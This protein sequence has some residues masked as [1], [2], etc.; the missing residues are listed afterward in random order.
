[1]LFHVAGKTL[2]LGAAF[3]GAV[4]LTA[5]AAV[6]APA[7]PPTF[8][9]DVAPIFQAKCE[10][11]HRPNSIAPMSLMS[12]EET[13]PWAR[14]IKTRIASRQMPP[15]HIDKTVG[16]QHFENDRSLSDE[17]IDTI[18]R[19]VD[20]GS[21]K[22]DPKDM[23]PPV[24]W[25]DDAG[26]NFKSRFGEPD[27]IVKSPAYRMPARA[28][29]AWY[30]P[31]VPTGLTEARW[32]RAIEIRPSTIK[33]RRIT[34]HALARL[35]QDDGTRGAAAS[36][37]APTGDDADV[38]PGLFMEWAVGK[39]GEVMRPNSGKLMLPG[40]KIV[41]DI[42]YHA[43]GE[44]ITDS[45]ELA[46]YFYP[47][48]QEPKFRQVLALFSGVTEG[49]RNLDIPPN[50][51]VVNQ[52]FHVMRQAGRVEN[53]QPHMHLRGKAM[54]MEAILPSGTTQMLSYVNDF[55]FNWHVNYVYAEDA[56]PLLPKGTI[57]RIT[58]WHDNTA[59]NKSNPDPNQWVGWGDRTVDEMA[60]A[61]VN[62]TY[63]SDED[64]QAELARRKQ[65][66]ARP[67]QSQ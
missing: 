54:A 34:H 13:R 21:P 59:G 7:D 3:A 30:K 32:V 18:V 27:L 1:M 5:S 10:A 35:Q 50:A 47:K 52:N 29:D 53:F 56:A 19:W 20:A 14:S 24:K 11:C 57:L 46:V 63:M 17:Q 38:G 22:G 16:I 39:Q 23:P 65:M 67:T 48:G 60:H 2:T 44:E 25:A 36:T 15:W 55:Q 43:V 28:Q 4:I 62:I 33:G 49:N 26:W 9:R 45:V 6:A 66:T 40:S 58:A 8:T 61:W 12:F 41:W 37:A 64:Y 31:V 42:H 51:V